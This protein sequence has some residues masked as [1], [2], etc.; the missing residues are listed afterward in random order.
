MTTNT[1]SSPVQLLPGTHH[2]K[3]IVDDQWRIADD[4]AKAVDDRDGSLANYVNVTIP[5]SSSSPQSPGYQSP[6]ASPNHTHSNQF[7][8]FFSDTSGDTAAETRNTSGTGPTHLKGEAAW[9]T[10]IPP[11]LVQAAAEEENYLANAD[12]PTTSSSVPAPNIPPAPVLPRHLDKLILNVRPVGVT[13]SPA[14][15]VVNG[16]GSERDRDRSRR[17][18][19]TRNHRRTERESRGGGR[20]NLGMTA[21]MSGGDGTDGEPS[22]PLPVLPV[23]TASGTDVTAALSHPQTPLDEPGTTP[24]TKK[25]VTARLDGPGLADDASVL[26]VPNHVVLHHL[27]TSAIRNGV[28]A[29]A[30]TTRYRKKVSSFASGTVLRRM[31]GQNG[32]ADGEFVLVA[33]HYDDLIQTNMMG[34]RWRIAIGIKMIFSSTTTRTTRTRPCTLYTHTRTRNQESR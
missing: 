32:F 29:V 24:T 25:L 14:P 28:L 3:F 2:F 21:T 23:V 33:V 4:Y 18:G 11:E 1:W 9:T 13:G 16:G 31:W 8:S 30:N 5:A 20:S 15:S 26:P 7:H 10:V 12:S 22:S 19:S 17:S 34:C 27:S 6:L